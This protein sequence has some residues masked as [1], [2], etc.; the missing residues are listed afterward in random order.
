MEALYQRLTYLALAVTDAPGRL[1]PILV[2]LTYQIT[3]PVT[4]L[5]PL[6]DHIFTNLLVNVLHT[7][8]FFRYTSS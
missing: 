1:V 3:P 7:T 8:R 5:Y 4:S 2:D 6:Q